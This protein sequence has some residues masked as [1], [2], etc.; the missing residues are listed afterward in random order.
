MDVTDIN[1]SVSSMSF[2]S[3]S[4]LIDESFAFG[5]AYVGHS[6]NVIILPSLTCST[7]YIISRREDGGGLQ[8]TENSMQR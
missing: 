1:G 6:K 5:T 2:F 8:L 7:Y 4:I 3:A